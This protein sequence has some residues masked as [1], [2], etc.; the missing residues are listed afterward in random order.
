MKKF[1]IV[2]PPNHHV[3]VALADGRTVQAR[4]GDV[5]NVA[6]LADP[7]FADEAAKGYVDRGQAEW[8]VGKD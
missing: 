4:T 7:L 8:V 2:I 1:R 3:D 6:D 5:F